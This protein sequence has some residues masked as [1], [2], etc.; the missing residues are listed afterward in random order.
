MVDE[1]QQLLGSG[2]VQS[3]KVVDSEGRHVLNIAIRHRQDKVVQLLLG[4]DPE[5]A[6]LPDMTAN[7]PLHHAAETGNTALVAQL[8]GHKPQLD[9][10]NLNM[11]D[12]STG[13]WVVGEDPIMPVDKVRLG[14]W[15]FEGRRVGGKG[16]HG[17]MVRGFVGGRGQGE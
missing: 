17:V 9:M 1:L 2:A 15:V 6:I 16:A 3:L 8:L 14:Q 5:L 10:Q 13:Q 4:R 11:C 12:Y 7:T